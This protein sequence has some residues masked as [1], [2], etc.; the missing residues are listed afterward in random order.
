MDLTPGERAVLGQ[1][2]VLYATAAQRDQ[3]V[4]ALFMQWTPTHYETYK[5]AYAGLVA[6]RLIQEAGAQLFRIT[7]AG[8]AAIGVSAPRPQP[9]V[10]RNDERPSQP[11]V[12][13]EADRTRVKPAASGAR[14][15]LSRWVTGLLRSRP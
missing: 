11:V 3:P 1:I 14:G 12:S 2:R 9:R 6:K 8:L 10:R 4:K 5:T 15:A 13:R 7:D